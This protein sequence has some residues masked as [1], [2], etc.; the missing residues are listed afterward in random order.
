V[1][2]LREIIS[3]NR[4]TKDVK[5]FNVG[6]EFL[7][8]VFKAHLTAAITE[9]L[10]IDTLAT[11]IDHP[12]SLQWFEDKAKLIVS[13][14]LMPSTSTDPVYRMHRSLLHLS[15]LYIGL[16]EAIRCELGE[17]IAR[18][19]KWWLPCFIATG[20]SNYATEAVHL[21]TNLCANFPKH[22]SYIATHNRTVNMQ[23]KDG[24]A[25]P[26]DQLVEHYNLY[27]PLTTKVIILYKHNLMV[28]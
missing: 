4:V 5:V 25:K 15:F 8:H 6:D 7:L 3:R 21:I 13:K 1:C 28:S 14:V 2:N 19:W 24:R 11:T 20:C 26:L 12:K 9:E 27:V 17:H 10:K 22:I 16:R 23:G 18:H